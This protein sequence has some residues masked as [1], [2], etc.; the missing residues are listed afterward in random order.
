MLRVAARVVAVELD[1]RLCGELR[2]RWGHQPRLTLIEGDGVTCPLPQS[3]FKVFANLP[4]SRTAELLRKLLQADPTPLDCYV[5][6]QREAAEKYTA[7]ARA[8]SLAAML[9]YPW[10]ESAV[11]HHFART[12]F[13]PAPRVDSVLLRLTPRSAPLLDPGATGDYRDYMAWRFEHDRSVK[14]R[15][16]AALVDAYQQ[17]ARSAGRN[18][19]AAVRGA[20]AR[21]AAQQA[22]LEKCHR[23]RRD[24][25][26]RRRGTSG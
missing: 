17:F 22:G 11:T 24:P 16:A 25:W 18:Q 8:N 15:P 3:P 19:R 4:F 10:W 9:Y 23:T 6:V 7:H 1:P 14:A 21:L 13:R 12:D 5:I 26:W 20:Y 2:A